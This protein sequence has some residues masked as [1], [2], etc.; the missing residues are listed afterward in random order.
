MRHPKNQIL[1]IILII[2]YNYCFS[3][4]ASQGNIHS[5][6]HN[7]HSYEIVKENR[8]W[9]SATMCAT[10]SGGYLV[11]IND[12]SEQTAILNE[13]LNGTSL[14]T[15]N[16]QNQSGIASIWVGG[17]DALSE[18]NWI[19]DGDGDG[20]GPQFWSGQSNGSSVGG[21]FSNWGNCS[22]EPN[23]SGGEDHLSIIIEGANFGFWN[24]I[25]SFNNIYYIIEYDSVLSIQELEMNH[26]IIIH[27]NPFN[28]FITVNNNNSMKITEISI[29][30]LLGKKIK[31]IT[32]DELASS[33]IDVS[34]LDN[35]V[36]IVTVHFEN[37]KIINKK[38]MKKMR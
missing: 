9:T 5:F 30:N 6:T 7:G 33:Q 19:W 2:S 4:C 20:I 29:I 35:G 36:Y 28:D 3:Q 32:H 25:S 15:S 18:G 31:T 10:D 26:N 1:F 16:T 27:P 14:N 24:D 11:E 34:N 17:N 22:T 38:I 12:L 8:S 23:N 13:I 21:L 37:G